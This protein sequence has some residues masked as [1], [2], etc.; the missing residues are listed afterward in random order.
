MMYSWYEYTLFYEE[1][2]FFYVILLVTLRMKT[3]EKW[4]LLGRLVTV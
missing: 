4:R 2:Q 3:E 1:S